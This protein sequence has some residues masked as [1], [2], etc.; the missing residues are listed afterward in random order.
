MSLE[1][2][3]AKAA[4][5]DF[6][7]LHAFLDAVDSTAAIRAVETLYASIS[8]LKTHPGLGRPYDVPRNVREI[9]VK[10]KRTAYVVRY[11]TSDDVILIL[12][13]WHARED[14]A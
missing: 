12:R 6:E 7:R 11:Q 3:Y 1:I 8:D 2:R 9:I 10:Y 5:D 13:I 14:R 4:F